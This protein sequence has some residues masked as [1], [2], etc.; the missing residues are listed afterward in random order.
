MKINFHQ[1]WRGLLRPAAMAAVLGSGVVVASSATAAIPLAKGGS[2]KPTIVLVHGAFA[3]SGSWNDVMAR[4][5]AQNYP[6]VAAAVPLR[7][8]QSDADYVAAIFQGIPG[9]IV[10]VGHS[11]GGL[12]ISDAAAGNPRV[13]ALVF[14]AAF[15]PEAGESAADLSGRFPGSTLEPTLAAPIA[16]SGGGKDLYIQQDKYRAQFAADVPAAAAKLMAAAQR[17]I[18]EAA[19]HEPA[20]SATWQSVPSWFVFGSLDKNIPAAAHSFMAARA[21]ARETVEIKGASHVVMISHPDAVARLICKAALSVSAIT[22]S[23]RPLPKEGRM[24]PLDGATAWFNSPQLTPSGLRGKVVL[25]QFWTYSCINW[26]RT[27]PYVRAWAEK[28]KDHGLVVIGVHSPEFEFEK[29]VENVRRAAQTR[30]IEYPVAIDSFHVLWDAFGNN[31]WPA[32]YL[33]DARGQIRYHHF[34]EGEYE[35]LERAIQQLLLEAGSDGCDRGLVL[36]QAS[37]VEAAAQTGSLES[38]ENYLGVDRT[39]NFDPR[40]GE[41]LGRRR[42]YV[43]P[44]QMDLNHWALVGDWNTGAHAIVL[45]Q[46]GG[47]IVYRFHA[48]D[49][50]VVMGAVAPGASVRFRVLIDGRPPGTAHGDDIDAEGRGVVAEPRLYQLVRQRDPVVDRRFEIEFLES[51]VEAFSVTFG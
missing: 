3:E 5:I 31:Y 17:P 28:Y 22:E 49:L 51:G 43:A 15:A 46:A 4:L 2:T 35:H 13:K 39:T 24:P 16:L 8:L 41:L 47:R 37:G 42:L 30:G 27:L 25:V 38:P 19:L 44:A 26:L 34:G 33:V 40:R 48:R 23:S 9:P 29:N 12:V 1:S 45:K 50:H 36:V 32:I 20:R 14:V 6:V 7:G 11:Y 18:T 10:A 21:H